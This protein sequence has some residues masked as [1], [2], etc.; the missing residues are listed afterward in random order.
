ML[1]QAM[2]GASMVLMFYIQVTVTNNLKDDHISSK[3]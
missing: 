2:G 3:V 1:S